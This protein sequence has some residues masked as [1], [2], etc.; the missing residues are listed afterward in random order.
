MFGGVS[1]AL[2]YL[3]ALIPVAEMP[4]NCYFWL[5]ME[6]QTKYQ[7][8][9]LM[10]KIAS[11]KG[12]QAQAVLNH[13][14]GVLYSNGNNVRATAKLPTTFGKKIKEIYE[15]GLL[16]P[17][18]VASYWMTDALVNQFAEDRLVF[19][20]VARKPKEAELFHEI[21]EMIGRPYIVFNLEVSDEEVFRRSAGRARDVVDNPKTLEKRLE[22]F[23][24]H[25][26]QSIAFFRKQST[27][28]DI[29]GLKSPEAVTA[30]IFNYLI[31]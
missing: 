17:E 15:G 14:G 27:L 20:G 26:A 19:E 10:G 31:K 3:P 2:L 12:T 1:N 11:G 21:H 28:I 22:E 24:T 9:V 25:T 30:E 16:I 13:F 7:S 18:W 4:Q 29:D 8:I 6:Q 5:N 23:N